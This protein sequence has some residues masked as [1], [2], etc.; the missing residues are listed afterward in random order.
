MLVVSVP[1]RGSYELHILVAKPKEITIESP[2]LEVRRNVELPP[3][4]KNH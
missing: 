2:K 1:Q 3:G 4:A